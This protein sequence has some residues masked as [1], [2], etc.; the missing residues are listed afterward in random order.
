MP[1]FSQKLHLLLKSKN[2]TQ[3]DAAKAFGVSQRAISGWL[4]GSIPRMDKIEKIA[5]YFRIGLEVLTDNTK[6]LPSP[7]DLTNEV[8]NI[9]ETLSNSSLKSLLEYTEQTLGR[10][11]TGLE[12]QLF[13]YI[14]MLPHDTI[15]KLA[16]EAI[17]SGENEIGGVLLLLVNN[18][19]RFLLADHI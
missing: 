19:K 14:S 5:S 3:Q 18:K 15:L 12:K 6:H 17:K 2:M 13:K 16:N 4:A 11:Y 8:E 10:K 9:L 7:Y 1:D